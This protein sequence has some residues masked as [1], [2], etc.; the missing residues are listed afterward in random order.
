MNLEAINKSINMLLANI[1][2]K[3]DYASFVEGEKR[4]LIVEGRTDEKF[5][6]PIIDRDVVCIVANK[7]FASRGFDE[8]IANSKNAIMQVVYGLSRIP[9]LIKC[10]KEILQC[11]IYGMVDKD[12][13]E[14][15]E[16]YLN[17]SKLFVTD[18]HDLE[19]LMISTDK[20]L[21]SKLE[22]CSVTDEEVANALHMAYQLGVL[23]SVLYNYTRE[24]SFKDIHNHYDKVF[25]E[26]LINVKSL[27]G[28]LNQL[29]GS[30]LSKGKEQSLLKKV[31]SDRDLKKKIDKNGRWKEQ[32]KLP[33]ADD[34]SGFWDIVNGHDVLSALRFHNKTLSSIFS[35][36]NNYALN[37]DFELALIEKYDYLMLRDTSLFRSMKREKVCKC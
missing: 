4:L 14:G 17:T 24:L 26:C 22:H 16:E 34:R 37:R 6:E 36:Q 33:S 30:I 27:I 31:L 28:V 8:Q 20:D 12:Y 35:N 19:T 3:Y 10:P 13:D 21:F 9:V 2:M 1:S 25:S 18:T 7:A 11:S 23:K 5:V 15:F 32:F 29:N